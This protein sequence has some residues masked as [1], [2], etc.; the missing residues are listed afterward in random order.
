MAH[1]GKLKESMSKGFEKHFVNKQK[2]HQ[3]RMMKKILA[4]AQ[5]TN[6]EEYVEEI[7][8]EVIA[9]ED[10]ASVVDEE[11]VVASGMRSGKTASTT[12]AMLDEANFITEGPSMGAKSV[13]ALN[14]VSDVIAE[15]ES[16][17]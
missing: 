1:K 4:N 3:D 11:A 8:E 16:E 13:E 2:V 7:P 9:V 14:D 5:A 12:V 15:G 6:P 17:I 10:V